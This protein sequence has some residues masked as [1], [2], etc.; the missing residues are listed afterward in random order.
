MEYKIEQG[1][2]ATLVVTPVDSVKSEV[3]DGLSEIRDYLASLLPATTLPL[4]SKENPHDAGV[5]QHVL[6]GEPDITLFRLHPRVLNDYSPPA[7]FRTEAA[8]VFPQK[9]ICTMVEMAG[10]VVQ[11]VAENGKG[12]FYTK[13]TVPIQTV[14]WGQSGRVYLDANDLLPIDGSAGEAKAYRVWKDAQLKETKCLTRKRI[15]KTLAGSA[16]APFKFGDRLKVKDGRYPDS[17]VIFIGYFRGGSVILLE[18]G[19]VVQ[20]LATSYV[21]A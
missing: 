20:G 10:P 9:N 14:G 16:D 5:P 6:S 11:S 15:M 7:A 12:Q 18:N 13:Y 21:K 1:L 19:T 4:G 8:R 17:E 2:R 3:Y